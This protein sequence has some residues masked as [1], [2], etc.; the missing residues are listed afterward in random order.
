MTTSQ[1]VLSWG[2]MQ[3]HHPLDVVNKGKVNVTSYQVRRQQT[4][5][6]KVPIVQSGIPGLYV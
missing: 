5:K 2:G 1:Q 6:Y 4:R 3:L